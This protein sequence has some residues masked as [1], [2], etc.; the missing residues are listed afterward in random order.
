MQELRQRHAEPHRALHD[1]SRIADLLAQ[2]E[3]LA[4]AIADRPAFV[5]AV[6]FHSA[7]FD[8]SL[9]GGP[10]RSAA[11]MQ[12]RLAATVHPATL[13]RAEALILALGRGAI[14]HT[15]DAS[16]RGDA[17]LLLDMDQAW[18]GAEPARFAALEAANRRE[19]AHLKEAAYRAGRAAQLRTLLWQE[20]IF[21]TDRYYLACE[22]RA[23]RNIETLLAGLEA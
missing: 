17:A 9:P 20:R 22:R 15:G 5:L 19:F 13:A 8:R 14:P 11:L 2:A 1:W 23:R 6:L 18:L 3:E 21:R 16:L 10:E 12:E 4:G 7:V